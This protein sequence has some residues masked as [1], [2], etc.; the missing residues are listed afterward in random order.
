MVSLDELGQYCDDLLAAPT[1][2]D[3]APNGVQV[4][5][6]RP[7]ARLVSGV[8]ASK[9]FLE[10]ALEADADAV[11]VHHGYSWKGEDARVAGM[12]AQRLRLLLRHDIGLLVYHLPLDAHPVYGNNAQLGQRL[13]LREQ[14]RHEVHGIPGLLGMGTFEEP[15][16]GD[17]LAEL[18]SQRLARVPVH[19][20][21]SDQVRRV[22]ICTGAGQ[23]FLADAARLGAD[24]LISGEISEPTAHE[25]RELGVQYFAAGHHATE[26][27]GPRALGD[28]LAARFDLQ[29]LFI[30]DDNPA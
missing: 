26:R 25:A 5:A 4:A 30:D 21:P 27:D 15:I 9:R 1:F 17:E 6:E 20:G 14:A 3:F 2:E 11:L 19:V 24:A 10:A 23:R 16:A 7:V 8:T 22:A 12:K 29:H 28:H 18:L 13:G